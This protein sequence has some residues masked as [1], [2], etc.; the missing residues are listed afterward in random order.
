[1]IF[2]FCIFGMSNPKTHGRIRVLITIELF[3]TIVSTKIDR[4][5]QA[6]DQGSSV[7]MYI[8][9]LRIRKGRSRF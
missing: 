2:L 6:S 7:I 3:Q 1:M 4:V 9:S 5:D 8:D